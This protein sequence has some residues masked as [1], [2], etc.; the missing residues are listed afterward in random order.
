[1]RAEYNAFLAR[2]RAHAQ[3][4]NKTDTVVRFNT[5]GTPV[6]ANY[7]VA[8]PAVPDSLGDD[9]YL[10]LQAID[11]DRYMSFD[12]RVVAVDAD[13][14]MML[15]EAVMAQLIRFTLTVPGRRCDPIRMATDG[16][17]EGRVEYDRT[18]RLYYVDMSY[19][20]WSH[21]AN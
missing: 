5:D 12:V 17:E 3:L 19:E 13:G 20:F 14:L 15:V 9:R 21:R 6:R 16:V 8:F 1:M 10:A 11:S 2:L 18:A 7:V 4:A